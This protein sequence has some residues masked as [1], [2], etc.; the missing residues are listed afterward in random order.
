MRSEEPNE[1][2]ANF[3]PVEAASGNTEVGALP[4]TTVKGLYYQA[5]WGSDLGGCAKARRCRRRAT[6]STSA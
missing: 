4:V 5:A 1:T 3:Y 6:R 2:F